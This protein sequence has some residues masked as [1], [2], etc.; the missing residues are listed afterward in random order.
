V[1]TL[2]SLTLASFLFITVGCEQISYELYSGKIMAYCKN[3]VAKAKKEN[4]LYNKY[5]YRDIND[6]IMKC[7]NHYMDLYEEDGTEIDLDGNRVLTKRSY[8]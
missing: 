1:K 3:D 8:K 6:S 7:Y 2:I 5:G 4:R